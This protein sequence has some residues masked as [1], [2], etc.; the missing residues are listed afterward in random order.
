VVSDVS[1]KCVRRRLVRG[2][3]VNVPALAG[4]L[5][6]PARDVNTVRHGHEKNAHGP[7]H[8]FILTRTNGERTSTTRIHRRSPITARARRFKGEAVAG[9]CQLEQVRNEPLLPVIG[10]RF[11]SCYLAVLV[12]VEFLQIGAR[13]VAVTLA[14]TAAA[15][16]TLRSH[17]PKRPIAVL[18]LSVCR[19][20]A[21]NG[22]GVGKSASYP[23]P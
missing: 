12:G 6:N 19:T 9:G 21:C 5:V 1:Q 22:C 18:D 10:G 17:R 15:P 4:H 16:E 3:E 7:S 2:D 20:E 13:S 23:R 11:L 14:A 8:L